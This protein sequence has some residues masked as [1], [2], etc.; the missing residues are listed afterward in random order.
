MIFLQAMVQVRTWG[1]TKI[2]GLRV[3]SGESRTCAYPRP[4]HYNRNHGLQWSLEAQKSRERVIAHKF[5]VDGGRIR[6]IDAIIPFHMWCHIISFSKFAVQY[7]D[8]I[9]QSIYVRKHSV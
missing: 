1:S 4:S 3:A 5:S 9:F 6:H 8:L 2:L 7:S